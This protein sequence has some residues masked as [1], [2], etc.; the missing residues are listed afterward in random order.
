MGALKRFEC[1]K[2]GYAA[3]V[4][5]DFDGPMRAITQVTV[6]CE[7]CKVI[8]DITIDPVP[9]GTD[10]E[11]IDVSRIQCPDSPDH[12]VNRWKHPGPCPQCGAMMEDRGVL[13]LFD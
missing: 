10:R 4:S 13:V 2:C 6:L 3:E 8:G 9:W 5:G 11:T 12:I 7:D 1:S